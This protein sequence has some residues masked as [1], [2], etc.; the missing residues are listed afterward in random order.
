M[1]GSFGA[2][3]SVRQRTD[4][5]E[6]PRPVTA[7]DDNR[8]HAITA[9]FGPLLRRLRATADLTQEELAERAGV[10]AR[11]ISDLERGL[12]QRPRRDTVQ[13]LADGLELA[14]A[15]R[16][17]F[18]AVARG[19]SSAAQT[20][21]D[22]QAR[23]ASL[24]LPPTALVGRERELAATTS[25]LLQPAL[26]LLTLTGP[27]G[28]GKTR[29]AIAAAAGVVDAFPHGVVFIDLAPLT[30]PSLVLPAI[31]QAFGLRD[32]DEHSLTAALHGRRVLVVLDSIEHLVAAAPAIARL[33][34]TCAGLTIFATSRQPLHLRA[35]HEYPVA[36][37]VLPDLRVLPP[38]DELGRVPAVELFVLRAEAARHTFALNAGNAGT[39]AEIAVRLDGLPLALELAAAR[40]RMLTPAELLTRLEQRL[41]LLAGGPAD[42]P[43]RQRTL[44]ATIAWSYGL[45]TPGEQRV[46]RQ[47][48]VF[49]G[50]CTL[51]AAESVAGSLGDPLTVLDALTALIDQNLLRRLEQPDDTVD[52]GA[53]RFGMLETIREY[54][55]EQ[56]VAAGEDAATRERHAAWCLACVE[57]AALELE[58]PEQTQC[59]ARLDAEHDNLRAALGWAIA[60]RDAETALR[61]TGALQS[62]WD[63]RCLYAEGRRW[64][65]QALAL[66]GDVPP[67]ARAKALSAAGL[68]AHRQGDYARAA[69]LLE[70]ALALN[71]ALR[72]P[73]GAAAA[74]CYLGMAARATGDVARS[75]AL[76]EEALSFYRQVGDR[77]GAGFTLS[78]LGLTARD[79]G[80][81]ARAATLLEEALAVARALGTRSGVAT[82]CNNLTLVALAQGDDVLAAARQAEALEEWRSLSDQDGLAHCFENFA[83]IAAAR[84][85]AARAARLFGA[86]EALRERIGAPGRPSDR[87][88][89]ARQIAD[90]RAQLGEA[91]FAA[92]WEHGRTMSLDDACAHA[93]EGS[94][95]CSPHDTARSRAGD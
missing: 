10:S 93:L 81:Y 50:G 91:A 30:D 38:P 87:E 21:S 74:Q 41:P 53:P 79:R 44:R 89:N 70:Q 4:T 22:T 20:A 66:D 62:F 75:A 6:G 60:Q 54:G 35:E 45:L 61:L 82:A 83:L 24:P 34:A 7:N 85:E 2:L 72:D 13:L 71:Q 40:I 58:G 5:F 19:T 27:G 88:H 92:A 64:L 67:A 76:H 63:V 48:A 42:L 31:A 26:R 68:V 43:A 3:R 15:A 73:A 86:A 14:G 16:D 12:I 18:V 46:F 32:R 28:V 36:P 11:L 25:L 47:L 52:W 56:L 78:N 95:E 1:S 84:G 59:L 51:A 39:V 65:E 55:L 37:L 33:L 94:W 17:R 90:G 57:R 69:V 80:D 29:L 9:A 8:Q 23:L 77:R 49:A